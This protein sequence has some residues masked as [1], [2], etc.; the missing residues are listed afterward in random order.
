M[1][2]ASDLFLDEHPEKEYRSFYYSEKYLIFFSYSEKSS[3]LLLT[4]LVEFTKATVPR[5]EWQEKE[6]A[7][8][9]PWRHWKTDQLIT[10]S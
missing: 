9:T 8:V 7:L 6:E 1:V 10:S 4:P 3:L 2:I 5:G